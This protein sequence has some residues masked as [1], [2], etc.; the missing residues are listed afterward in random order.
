MTDNKY[1]SMFSIEA[2]NYVNLT[3]PWERR[4]FSDFVHTEITS[5]F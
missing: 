2:I 4:L 3:T 1:I 5:T